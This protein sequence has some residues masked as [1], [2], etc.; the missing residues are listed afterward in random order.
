MKTFALFVVL[1]MFAI[2]LPAVA[3]NPGKETPNKTHETVIDGKWEVTLPGQDK[4]VAMFDFKNE[5]G[6]VTGVL[7]QDG[8]TTEIKNGTLDGAELK[9]QTSHLATGGGAPM[10]MSW[11]GMIVSNGDEKAINLT[12]AMQTEDG[13]PAV[14]DLHAQQM[15]ARRVK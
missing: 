12:C 6:I 4:P 14:G 10:T 15:Q 7:T 3:Q 9:F 1:G 5:S 8:K 11:T 13:G 2:G